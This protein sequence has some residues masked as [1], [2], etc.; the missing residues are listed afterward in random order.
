MYE[1]VRHPSVHRMPEHNSTVHTSTAGGGVAAPQRPAQHLRRQLA[2]HLAALLAVTRRLGPEYA[3][4]AAQLSSRIEALVPGG[5]PVPAPRHR[6]DESAETM[7]EQAHDLAARV[8]VVAAAQ[9]D[10]ATAVLACARMDAHA[11]ARRASR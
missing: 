4:A 1:P 6:A 7:H 11:A 9:Q 3:D 2:G 5:L 8:L 10:T